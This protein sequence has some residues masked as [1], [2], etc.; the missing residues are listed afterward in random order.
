MAEV[1]DS[2]T[3]NDGGAGITTAGFERISTLPDLVDALSNTDNKPREITSR[4][5]S[6]FQN[7]LALEVVQ[8]KDAS[9]RLEESRKSH[10]ER[11]ESKGYDDQHDLSQ[12]KTRLS[13]VLTHPQDYLPMIVFSCG[14]VLGVLFF[15][16]AYGG[17]GGGQ[18]ACFLLMVI[19]CWASYQLRQLV[20]FRFEIDQ[21]VET[22]Q[23]LKEKIHMLD[24]EIEQFDQQ[25]ELFHEQT[26]ELDRMNDS[27][28]GEIGELEDTFNALVECNEDAQNAITSFEEEIRQLN[29]IIKSAGLQHENL[30]KTNAEMK[31]TLE[32]FK[33][34]DESMRSIAANS[35]FEMEEML[36]QQNDILKHFEQLVNEY[37]RSVLNSMADQFQSHLD[38]DDGGMSR[39]EYQV[40]YNRLPKRFQERMQQREICFENWE[41]NGIISDN[42]MVKLINHLLPEEEI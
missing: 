25:N 26:Q 7:E 12:H 32:G 14:S 23:A 16:M 9:E 31:R 37:A 18:Y 20:L 4:K 41:E 27:L 33:E 24:M 11:L 29:E 5:G 8:S 34:L 19:G 6:R 39:D 10:R 17:A 28:R 35:D 22:R 3:S 1:R 36:S 2:L 40:W 13:D 42:Q 21:L 15:M 38:D 30:E